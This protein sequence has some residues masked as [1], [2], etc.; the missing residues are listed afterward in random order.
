MRPPF[1]LPHFEPEIGDIACLERKLED[2]TSLTTKRLGM[3]GHDA[4]EIMGFEP[5]QETP[6]TEPYAKQTQQLF[7]ETIKFKD[8]HRLSVI[9]HIRTKPTIS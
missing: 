7:W 4:I 6:S 5:L 9:T 8:I 3:I 1:Y 2:E